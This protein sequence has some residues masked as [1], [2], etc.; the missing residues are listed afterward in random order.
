MNN[1]LASHR[2]STA[3]YV[4][5]PRAGQQAA[6]A[7]SGHG[8]GVK[9]HAGKT[10]LAKSLIARTK[11]EAEAR[12]RKQQRRLLPD[13]TEPASSPFYRDSAAAFGS[14][15]ATDRSS[16]KRKQISA[17]AN[18]ASSSSSSSSSN[19]D[20][21]MS[22]KA[23]LRRL[24]SAHEQ[25]LIDAATYK[26]TQRALAAELVGLGPAAGPSASSGESNPRKK[27]RQSSS[28][29]IRSVDLF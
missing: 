7:P 23:R 20:N 8:T 1:P 24:K 11:T 19:S 21:G 5:G 27:Q 13:D 3:V 15:T 9:M 18:T 10:V 22:A 29:S 12:K 16:K 4:T 26:A 28:S 25:G 14:G 17:A 6:A 2:R